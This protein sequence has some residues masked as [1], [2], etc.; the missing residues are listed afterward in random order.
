RFSNGSPITADD[1]KFSFDTLMSKAAHPQFR[2]YYEDV[3][4]VT[5]VDE[6]T[7]RFNFKRKNRE[8]HMIIG[9][10]A[11]FSKAWL[12][13]G[14]FSETDDTPP[15]SS[16]PYIV[17]DYQRGKYIRYKRNPNYWAAS[18]PVRKGMYN[19]DRVTYKYYKDSTI[20]LEAFK[21][22][23]FDFF[24]EN[25]SKRWARS[26][27]GPKYE[28][29]EILKTELKH[30]NNAGMQ[31]F[32]INTRR[33]RFKD[34]RVRRALSLAYD[35]AWAN[36]HLFYNQYV[37][38]D[39]YFSNSELAA[40]GLPKDAELVLLNNYRDQLPAEVFSREWLPPSTEKKGAL[41]ENLKQ[42]RDL[43][44]QAGWSI[45][46]GV[47]QND[48][49]VIF[50]LDVL[51]VQKGFD[52]ILAPY[53]RNLK[54]LGIEMNYRTV[55]SSLYKRRIDTYDFD[56]VVTSYPASMSPGNELKSRFHS[57]VV[58][59]KGARNLSGVDHPVVDALIERVLNAENRAQ[60]LIASRALDRVL[61]FGEYLVPNWYI[62]KHRIAYRS[63]FEY[64][65]TL[66]LYYDPI[67]LLIKTW[68]KKPGDQLTSVD[69]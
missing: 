1:V 51:L 15:V 61:L 21:A 38:C 27:E 23:E 5:V 48:E 19:F 24:F 29:G 42:A 62:D 17:D 25:Y 67:T 39:S 43:L 58:N 36:D 37:R 57:Q 31:G 46:D 63:V 47:L 12:E 66:P 26:H 50:S 9:E 44:K 18:L 55:D 53:A 30:S 49:A 13:G 34:V 20:A 56:M 59:T 68:W 3:E 41:R 52:R 22:G 32:A 7:V 45:K 8:L 60:L 6:L 33:E 4:S 35:F 69:H 16:G 64:P 54:K 28:S 40:T 65:E 2:I 10:I 11:I 14:E